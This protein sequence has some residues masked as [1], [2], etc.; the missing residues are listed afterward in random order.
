MRKDEFASINTTKK[1]GGT[2]VILVAVFAICLAGIL[3][4]W[5]LHSEGSNVLLETGN[6]SVEQ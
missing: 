2:F 5:K 1:R 6:V 4:A 3:C